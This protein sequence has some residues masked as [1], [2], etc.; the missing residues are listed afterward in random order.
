MPSHVAPEVQKTVLVRLVGQLPFAL[1]GDQQAE[2]REVLQKRLREIFQR[3]TTN[4]SQEAAWRKTSL[5]KVVSSA[6]EAPWPVA[7]ETQKSQR[8]FESFSQSYIS[9]P[10]WIT[11]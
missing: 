11:G 8:P 5:V 6:A 3:I 1:T 4:D 7:S 2:R 9:P 10:T